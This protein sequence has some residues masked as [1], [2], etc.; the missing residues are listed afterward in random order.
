MRIKGNTHTCAIAAAIVGGEEER[1]DRV[2]TLLCEAPLVEE[3]RVFDW[4]NGQGKSHFSVRHNAVVSWFK[5]EVE[6][7]P[8]GDDY[9]TR[10]WNATEC[11]K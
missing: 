4:Q 6:W 3:T 8:C 7:P 5:A 2:G 10:E 11:N 1:G 9:K